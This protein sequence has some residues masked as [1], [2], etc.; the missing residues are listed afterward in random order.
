MEEEKEFPA[1]NTAASHLIS[2]NT[3]I[4]FM[5]VVDYLFLGISHLPALCCCI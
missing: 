4:C 1:K 2:I 5:L 3:L